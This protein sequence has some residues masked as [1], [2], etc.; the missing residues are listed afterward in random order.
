MTWKLSLGGTL[1]VSTIVRYTTEAT[2]LPNPRGFPFKNEIRTSG[3]D[4]FSECDD[5]HGG[6]THVESAPL[7]CY[8]RVDQDLWFPAR[9]GSHETDH[10][11]C[12]V[13]RAP[14]NYGGVGAGGERASD[15]AQ[16]AADGQ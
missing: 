6:L 14:G 3:M 1:M 16:R 8:H 11:V 15:C 4:E 5:G 2:S 10:E 7:A 13:R 9:S 12:R